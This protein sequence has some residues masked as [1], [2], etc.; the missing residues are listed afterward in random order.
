MKKNI[1]INQLEKQQTMENERL[2]S[3]IAEQT[4]LEN[5]VFQN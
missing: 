4:M 2:I 1:R 5:N 3:V